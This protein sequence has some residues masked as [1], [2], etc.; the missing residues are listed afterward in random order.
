MAQEYRDRQAD[1][2]QARDRQ[3]RQDIEKFELGK[4]QDASR[5]QYEKAMSD[6]GNRK[7]ETAQGMREAATAAYKAQLGAIGEMGGSPAERATTERGQDIELQKAQMDANATGQAAAAKATMDAIKETRMAQSDAVDQQYKQA[8]LEQLGQGL[9]LD[10]AA[11]ESLMRNRQAEQLLGLGNLEQRQTEADRRVLGDIGSVLGNVNLSR[12]QQVS[13]LKS[14]LG[15][16]S[17]DIIA[18]LLPQL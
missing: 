16:G 5:S 2:T 3:Y 13:L 12:Q 11:T 18:Q 4:A 1:Y 9:A 14:Y 17:D 15:E 6:I 10:E 8:R 7:G